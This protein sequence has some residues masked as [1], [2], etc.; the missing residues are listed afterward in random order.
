M[1]SD[2]AALS[3]NTVPVPSFAGVRVFLL[4]PKEPAIDTPMD[5]SAAMVAAPAARLS[6]KGRDD[7][8]DTTASTALVA[9]RAP[10]FASDEAVSM[11]R[12]EEHTSE[13]QSL[14][15]ISYAVFCLKK[16]KTQASK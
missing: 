5:A 15:R 1:L 3:P 9:V 8:A 7:M 11:A 6:G 16:K 13:L 2:F 14:M 4:P 12:S 10:L